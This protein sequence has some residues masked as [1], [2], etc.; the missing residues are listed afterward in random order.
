LCT[1]AETLSISKHNTKKLIDNILQGV[2]LT[3]CLM[4]KLFKTPLF[5]LI[6]NKNRLFKNVQGDSGGL[7]KSIEQ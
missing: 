6:S 3:I 2:S 1:E 7:I 5:T 4:E